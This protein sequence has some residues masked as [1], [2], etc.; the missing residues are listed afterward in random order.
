MARTG[1]MGRWLQGSCWV[2]MKVYT[3][4]ARGLSQSPSAPDLTR[5]C[6]ASQD[7]QG[8]FCRA[9]DPLRYASACDDGLVTEVDSEANQYRHHAHYIAEMLVA[10]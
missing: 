7:A 3:D 9:D 6:D 5:Q 8:S 4:R 2:A 1:L 10:M